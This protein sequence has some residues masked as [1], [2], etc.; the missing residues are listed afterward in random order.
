[1]DPDRWSIFVATSVLLYICS[2]GAGVTFETAPAKEASESG[3][4]MSV[5]SAAAILECSVL[6]AINFICTAGIA[7]QAALQLSAA[8]DTLSPWVQSAICVLLAAVITAAVLSFCLVA[9]MSIGRAE[10]ERYYKKQRWLTAL[11]IP[12]IPIV[13][14]LC[15]PAKKLLHRRGTGNDFGTVTEE[16]VLDDVGELDEIDD[17]QREMIGNIFELDDVTAGDIMTHRTEVEAVSEDAELVDIVNKAVS[18]GYSR[19]PVYEESLDN[20]IGAVSVKD[21]LPYVG[22]SGADFNIRRI[23]RSI[24]YVHESCPASDLMLQFKAHKL[25]LAVVVDEYG[26][27]AGIVSL[28]DILES[29]VGDIEDEYDEDEKLITRRSDGSLVCNG[30][31]GVDEVCVALAAEELDEAF[32][33]EQIESETIGGLLISLLGRIPAKGE[34]ASAVISGVELIALDS[35]ERRITRVLVHKI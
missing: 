1:M 8:A 15:V 31:A 2:L 11:A 29:I 12:F 28:E 13:R 22:R 27:T 18:T 3:I 5:R 21:L 23:M 19:L 17:N 25:P 10:H 30:L 7:R 26:G 16:D 32:K 9:P 35:D 14:L 4:G 33:N 34:R 24:L 20:I 6:M